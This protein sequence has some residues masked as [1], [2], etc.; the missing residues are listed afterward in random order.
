M[1]LEHCLY[2]YLFR[3]F[4]I[5]C[6]DDADICVVLI[7][8]SHVKKIRLK[9]EH[10]HFKKCKMNVKFLVVGVGMLGSMLCEKAR[11]AALPRTYR[12]RGYLG[13]GSLSATG[14]TKITDRSTWGHVTAE[15]LHR[16]LNHVQGAHRNSCLT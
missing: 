16:V 12:A 1:L 8:I 15:K 4:F 10:L 11:K 5:V 7:N 3:F 14:D 9:N 2:I 13:V 6:D